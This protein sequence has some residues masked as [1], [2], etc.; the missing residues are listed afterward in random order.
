MNGIRRLVSQNK[1]RFVDS[2][3]N[4]DLDLAYITQRIIAMGFPSSGIHSTYRNPQSAVSDFFEKNHPGH[5]KIFNLAEEP[6]EQS[7][8]SGPIEHFPFPDH[9]SPPIPVYLTIIKHAIDWLNADPL[10][11]IAVHC[12]AGMGRTGTVITAILQYM[13]LEENAEDSLYHFALI[14]TGTE[15]GVSNPCQVRYVYYAERIL[16]YNKEHNL[17]VYT[18]PS[19]PIRFLEKIELRNIYPK[20][21]K[22]VYI[23]LLNNEWDVDFNNAWVE[24]PS[25]TASPSPIININKEVKGDFTINVYRIDKGILSTTTKQIM[26]FTVS[27]A[28]LD[29]DT[30][31]ASKWQ[32]DNAYKDT[33]NE[34]YPADFQLILYFA[35]MIGHNE[36]IEYKLPH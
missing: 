6:Y 23:T 5:Y 33:K 16:R 24:D 36:R 27:T 31:I 35:P 28:F 9:H 1:V 26:Y 30:I 20:S 34:K 3:G 32:V 29:G 10:N 17:D 18:A 14:R 25:I 21:P 8:F 13:G 2:E 12:I 22:P 11:V 15:K 7:K 19:E 4:D